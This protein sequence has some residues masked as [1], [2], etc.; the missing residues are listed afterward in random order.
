MSDQRANLSHV[1]GSKT[2]ELV[3]VARARHLLR[4]TPPHIFE[5]THAFHFLS[6]RWQRILNSVWRDALMSKV[7][8]RRLMP[9]TTYP[10]TRARFTED[11][12]RTAI[13]NGVRQYV[14]LGAGFDTFALR[15]PQLDILI[16][17]IDLAS[18]I[19]VKRVRATKAGLAFPDNLRTIPIDFETERIIDKL[20]AH[21]FKPKERSFF[22]WLG[23]TYYLSR[24]AIQHTLNQVTEI[25][26]PGSELVLDYLADSNRIPEEE[27][28]RAERMKKYVNKRGEPMISPFDPTEAETA[29]NAG[30]NWD[31]VRNDSPVDQQERYVEGKSDAYAL[32][33]LFWCLHMRR[34][35][36]DHG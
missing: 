34:R 15:H 17:E 14:I 27:R 23:V 26:C 18:T 8:L 31:I 30:G 16:Y 29:L 13:E 11:C 4:H 20:T 22:N 6:E 10:L 12:L 2:A 7:I 21:G 33:P 3:A 9:T 35:A 28:L 24:D 25:A 5:D 36:P 19:A 1:H 32:P